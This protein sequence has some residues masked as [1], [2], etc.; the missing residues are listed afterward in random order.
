P[1]RSYC[2]TPLD[3]ALVP[4]MCCGECNPATLANNVAINT[5][6]GGVVNQAM[7]CLTV[8]C[9]PCDAPVPNPWLGVTC[10]DHRCVAF[11]LS[12]TDLVSCTESA[13]CRLRGVVQC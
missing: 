11:N 6:Y 8:D 10:R 1:E 5:A 13:D 3:C 4:S 12:R 9:N 7:G 2:D